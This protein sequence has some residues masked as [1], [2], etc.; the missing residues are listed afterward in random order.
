MR[1]TPFILATLLALLPGCVF[2]DDGL[3]GRRARAECSREGGRPVR[4]PRDTVRQEPASP[5]TVVLFSAVRFPEDYDWQRDSAY[6][7]VPF[8]LL[9]YKDGSPVLTL[10]SGT[11]PCFTTDP[12][13]HHL[14]SGHLYTERAAD[15]QT[16]IGRDG[17]ELFRF[18]GREYLLGLL[19]DGADLYTLSRRVTEGGFTFRKNGSILLERP[20]GMPYGSL[21]DPSYAPTGALYRD[22]GSIVFCYRT[23]TGCFL[24]LDGRE[25]QSVL[26]VQDYLDFRICG[27]KP[28]A[29]GS[30]FKGNRLTEGRIWPEGDSYCVTGCFVNYAGAR[31][32]GCMRPTDSFLETVICREEAVLYHSP[33]ASF[34]VAA[35]VDGRVYLYGAGSTGLYPLPCYF[36]SPKCARAVGDKLLVALTPKDTAQPPRVRLGRQ[37]KEVHIHGYISGVGIEISQPAS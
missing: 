23:R 18:D 19:E 32:Y 33:E 34:G 36:P 20:D 2:L 16:R 10:A 15:G 14:L 29:L 17:V 35:G 31:S 6:G 9:L 11:D 5:D 7:T 24:V 21:S 8:E 22:S 13:R 26:P 12:D 27:G 28:V 1:K 4:A 37:E 25:T 3:D 30:D